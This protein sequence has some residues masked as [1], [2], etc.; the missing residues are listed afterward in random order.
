VIRGFP[1]T[2]S[3]TTS[4]KMPHPKPLKQSDLVSDWLK[5]FSQKLHQSD[6]VAWQ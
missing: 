5:A 6:E 3:D 1:G 2:Q 4:W